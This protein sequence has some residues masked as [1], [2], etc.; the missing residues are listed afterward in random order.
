[1]HV[2]HN[3][4]PIYDENSYILILGSMPSIKSRYVGF[5]YSHPKNRFWSTLSKV[6]NE[7]IKDTKEDKINFLINH[8]I[9]LFDCIK[10]C[11][12]IGSSDSTIKNVIPNDIDIIINNSKIKYI[13]TTGRTSYNLYKKYIYPKTNI[14]AIYLPSPSPA[15]CKKGIEDILFKEY[16]KIK[17]VIDSH[18]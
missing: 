10:E 15:N 9:A 11:D 12:I 3:L 14:E 13:F 2:I 1:M 16:S 5:Y 18:V 7:K 8:H 6:F 17:S 4:N